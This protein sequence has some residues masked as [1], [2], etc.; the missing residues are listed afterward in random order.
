MYIYELPEWP[1]FHW[2]KDQLA[3]QLAELIQLQGRL[4]GRRE[5]LG[6]DQ[7][8]EATLQALTDD[9]VKSS[10][11]EGVRLDANR[12]SSSLAKRMGM[13]LLSS[14]GLPKSEEG[15]V[16]VLLDATAH[17]ELPLTQERMFK[18]H[19][20]LFPDGK[21]GIHTIKVGAWRDEVMQVVSGAMGNETVHYNAPHPKLMQTEMTAFLNWFN[22]P[23]GDD[24][25]RSAIAHLWF[26]MIHP[27]D[28]GNGRIARALADM[29]L[30]RSE[31]SS[32]RFYSMSSQIL[33]DRITYYRILRSTGEADLDITEWL[34]WY[35]DC[36]K[37][38]IEASSE[39][40]SGILLKSQ[41]WKSHAG[42]PINERQSAMIN[43]LLDGFHGKLTSSKWAQ[44]T[45]CSQDT[46]ARDIAG[47]IE[48][49]ILEKDEAGGRSTSYRLRN[50]P[51]RMRQAPVVI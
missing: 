7:H 43:R 26:V 32:Q 51:S 3:P 15:I 49:K 35:L 9:V 5:S 42:T 19:R 24:V 44:L 45:K 6:A 17:Y 34:T 11:I 1:K 21:S 30:A 27:F 47:M 2:D 16:E 28:D 37:K 18:W 46:A 8:Q 29:L 39:A 23:P 13:K 50:F 40:L 12:V 20:S 4:L 38:S 22:Q 14:P 33:K 10:Q 41:F 25:M 31:K 36:L 48:K